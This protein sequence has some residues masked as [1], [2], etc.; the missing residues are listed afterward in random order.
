MQDSLSIPPD[1]VPVTKSQER[2]IFIFLAVFLV[3]IMSIALVGS[4]GFAIWMSH[5]LLGPP[6]Y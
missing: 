4:Y 5:L 2:R 3:P 1:E 6:A